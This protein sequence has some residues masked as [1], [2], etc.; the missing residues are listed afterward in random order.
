[1]ANPF[2]DL[3]FAVRSLS[4]SP[5]YTLGAVLVLALGMGVALLSL[6]FLD[7]AVWRPIGGVS[8]P[9]DLVT[10]RLSVSYQAW[11]DLRTAVA[12][13]ADLAAFGHRT[14]VAEVGAESRLLAGGVATGN[15]FSVLGVEMASGRPLAESDDA[16]G[17]AVVVVSHAL[18]VDLAGT[19][20]A[21]LGRLLRLNGAPF[22]VVGVAAPEFRRL[23]MGA[24]REVWLTPHGW[25]TALPTSFPASLSLQRR[26][27]GW[28][29]PIARPRPGV[30]FDTVQA[31]LRA[32]GDAQAAQFPSE[33]RDNFGQVLTLQSAASAALGDAPPGLVKAISAALLAA[34]G[35]LLLLAC[36]NVAHLFSARATSRRRELA[37][38]FALGGGR[39]RV[40]SILVAEALV[41]SLLA[42][43]VA[44]GL[45]S[46][47]ATVLA[48]LPLQDGLTL[49]SFGLA[50]DLR[51]LGACVAL[52]LVVA[53]AFGVAPALRAGRNAAGLRAAG[54]VNGVSMEG[55]LHRTSARSVVIQV[56]LGFVL[57]S[58]STLLG[59]AAAD[60]LRN[61]VG[62]RAQG[63]MLAG[64][65][66]GLARTDP[67]RAAAAH[68]AV[69]AE[70]ARIP[71]VERVT[72]SQ[73]PPLS[74][75]VSSETLTVAGYQP[76]PD[77]QPE[78]EVVP[79]GA[80]YFETLGVPLQQGRT[81]TDADRAGAP[82][83]AVVNRAFAER[84]F[85][86]RSAV[87]STLEIIT[88]V[89]TVVGIVDNVRAH[90]LVEA[91]PPLLYVAIDQRAGAEQVFETY[92]FARTRDAIPGLPLAALEAAVRRAVPGVP[93]YEVG[94]FSDRW[95]AQVSP[96]RF[97]GA[98]LRF[99]GGLGL[100]LLASG[101]YAV[102]AHRVSLRRRE[103]GLRSALGATPRVLER[104]F[105][106]EGLRSVL[107]GLAIGA[108]LAVGVGFAVRQLLYGVHPADPV[109][110]GL[111]ALMVGVVS[112]LAAF[113]PA[114]GAARI[115]PAQA[116]RAEG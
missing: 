49:G 85:A 81:F 58:V 38:R 11:R 52:T 95:E 108:P 62:F 82:L 89:M 63:L 83:V 23:R 90:D 57:L 59:R 54:T 50:P 115:E 40:T 28:L 13:Q 51:S 74:G 27:W 106:G 7:A 45:V 6:R 10:A 9:A 24:P 37:T 64:Y 92:V 66:L 91:P 48:D 14:F 32:A 86:G 65:N 43:A 53:L 1:M 116:L 114:R 101:I 18:A 3:R 26:S 5:A 110:L 103:I 109:A 36:A 87:G 105:V 80:G 71:G 55:G 29:S 31:A 99:F 47:A 111:G 96:Q 4:R 46:L 98:A 78:A 25:T 56:A 112:A 94:P 8:R 97:I 70:V 15:L 35:S 102:V 2:Y 107:W 100:I 19:P 68:D 39:A 30:S 44:L 67:A 33:T 16:P 34:V 60:G 72:L 12:D 17:A 61:D 69:L 79:I 88:G 22:E 113:L 73:V 75:S 76:G 104:H 20:A 84:Y 77:E 21:A 42:G 93:V 41:L